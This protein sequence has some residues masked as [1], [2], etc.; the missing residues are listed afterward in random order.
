M[1]MFKESGGKKSDV[2]RISSL[3]KKERLSPKMLIVVDE[4]GTQ[5]SALFEDCFC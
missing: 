4:G 2:A 1:M 3:R 5:L